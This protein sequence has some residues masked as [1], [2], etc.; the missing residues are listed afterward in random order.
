M[1]RADLRFGFG[2][3]SQVFVLNKGNG[4]I[5]LLIPDGSRPSTAQ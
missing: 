5:R 2:G 1:T 4:T 3:D